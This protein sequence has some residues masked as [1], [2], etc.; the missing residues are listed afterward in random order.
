MWSRVSFVGQ[1][2]WNRRRGILQ[3]QETAH[4]QG[5]LHRQKTARRRET[6]LH[7]VIIRRE[8]IMHREVVKKYICKYHKPYI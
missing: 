8:I 3:R 4:C 2:F 7:K 1:E 5:I 6:I